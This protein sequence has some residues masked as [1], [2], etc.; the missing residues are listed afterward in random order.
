MVVVTI[1]V[2]CTC[3]QTPRNRLGQMYNAHGMVIHQFN[4]DCP[5]HGIGPLNL[6]PMKEIW[7]RAWM[8]LAHAFR[9]RLMVDAIKVIQKSPDGMSA[10]MEW[11]DYE[12]LPPE[13]K[14][15]TS[16][17]SVDNAILLGYTPS[18]ET[19]QPER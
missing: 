15:E 6:R 2:E 7:R 13:T 8:P 9:L 18:I 10:L 1:V 14:N 16:E 5:E 3:P 11:L 4:M 19:T 17:K 12:F